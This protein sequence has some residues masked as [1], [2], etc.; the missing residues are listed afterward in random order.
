MIRASTP[1]H[2]F[3]IPEEFVNQIDKLLITY[4]QNDKIVLEKTEQDV[5]FDSNMVYYTLKQEETN[6]FREDEI[7]EIQLRIKTIHG[8][9]IATNIYKIPCKRVLN[10]EVL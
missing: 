5:D 9:V 3:T 4:S 1:T 2:Y 7:V 10:D 6:L 8:N